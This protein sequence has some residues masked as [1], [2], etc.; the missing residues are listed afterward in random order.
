MAAITRI[1]GSRLAPLAGKVVR[2]GFPDDAYSM[3]DLKDKRALIGIGL[4]VLVLGLA[5]YNLVSG[6]PQYG[7]ESAGVVTIEPEQ[8]DSTLGQ[9][10]ATPKR[11]GRSSA[12]RGATRLD[13]GSDDT[14]NQTAPSQE[15][16]ESKSKKRRERGK[17][18]R[19]STKQG[20]EEQEDA[21]RK[22]PSS[23]RQRG[24]PFRRAS[25]K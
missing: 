20:E 7:P 23:T 10:S 17:R 18:R 6:R 24:A 11:S 22:P 1:A 14:E 12:A 21:P 8:D 4:G 3:I 15:D 2:S 13:G 25:G 5:A 19:S 16:D 9:I